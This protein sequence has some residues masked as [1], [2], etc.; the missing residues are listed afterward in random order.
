MID[1]I[2][3][4]SAVHT[5]Y[6]F[7]RKTLKI[8]WDVLQNPVQTSTT[9]HHAKN[10]ANRSF[11]VGWMFRHDLEDMLIYQD[12]RLAGYGINIVSIAESLGIHW[13]PICYRPSRKSH[14]KKDIEATRF[15]EAALLM[16]LLERMGFQVNP[17][18]LVDL[19]LPKVQDK[20]KKLL[21]GAEL[22]ILWYHE[23]KGKTAPLTLR[24]EDYDV[25]E[26]V[27]TIITPSKYKIILSG[28]NEENPETIE[29]KSP[30]YR[31]NPY[32][33]REKCTECGIEWRRGDPDSSYQH[34]KAHKAIMYFHNPYP[35][36]EMVNEILENKDAEL[37]D[38][39]SPIWKLKEIYGRAKEFRKEMKFDF[40][41]WM[42]PGHFN[43]TSQVGYL[44]VKEDCTIVGA[45][46]FVKKSKNA[47]HYWTLDWVWINPKERRMGHLKKR[48][49]HFKEK[50]GDFHISYPI[51]DSMSAF[52]K[53]QGDEAFLERV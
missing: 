5:E 42:K 21:S 3:K 8:I 1:H 23:T 6:I 53:N 7:E 32:Y 45:C 40:I 29:F 18:V 43:N 28:T 26:V 2:S 50:F 52:V 30:R 46:S 31:S 49:Q 25:E 47:V 17:S 11:D 12:D 20:S 22:Q 33:G 27:K 41:Q 44:F 36:K 39:Y 51:S 24:V 10:I 37:V 19:F 4:P 13:E 16:I 34:R 35:L 48:W 15:E 9:N 38:V 14:G